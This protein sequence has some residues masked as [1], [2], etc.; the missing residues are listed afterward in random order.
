MISAHVWWLLNDRILTGGV[1]MST[2]RLMNS[3]EQTM[4]DVQRLRDTHHGKN[5]HGNTADETASDK[6]S[7]KE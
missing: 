2:I 3:E 4:C 1:V 6:E 7:S 5:M